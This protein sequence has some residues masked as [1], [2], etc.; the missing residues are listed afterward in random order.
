MYML[1]S[2]YNYYAKGGMNDF[3]E[4]SESKE[5]LLKIALQL[6]TAKNEEHEGLE[7]EWWHIFCLKTG[8]VVDHSVCQAYGVDDDVWKEDLF[9]NFKKFNNTDEQ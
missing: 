1:F 8:K 7:Y 4:M 2:G 6:C 9:E 5:K 3:I